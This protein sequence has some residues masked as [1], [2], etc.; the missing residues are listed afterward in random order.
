M[1]VNISYAFFFNIYLSYSKDFINIP[2]FFIL[3]FGAIVL[4]FFEYNFD[5]EYWWY[6][7]LIM[8]NIF[9][10][11]EFNLIHNKYDV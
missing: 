5:A 6:L 7:V 1:I 10:V 3:I 11:I 2:L 9:F 4:S 8:L